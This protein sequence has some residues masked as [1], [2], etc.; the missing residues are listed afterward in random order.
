MAIT[1]MLVRVAGVTPEGLTEECSMKG[2]FPEG[3]VVLASPTTDGDTPGAQPPREAT[4]APGARGA[5][6]AS[7]CSLVRTGALGDTPRPREGSGH[8][9]IPN[10]PPSC[11]RISSWCFRLAA[12][13]WSPESGE[14]ERQAE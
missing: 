9:R 12:H 4:P 2:P 3:Q 10:L 7:S 1:V 5:Q 11:P 6:R 13:N 8:G 14:P